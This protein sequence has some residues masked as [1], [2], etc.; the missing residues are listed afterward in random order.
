[1]KQQSRQTFKRARTDEERLDRREHILET[2]ETLL[3]DQGIESFTMTRLA[4]AANLAKGTAYLYFPTKNDLLVELFTRKFANWSTR[5]LEG[6]SPGIA[7]EELAALFLSTATHDPLFM[8]L[9]NRVTDTIESE[10]TTDKVVRIKRTN[11]EILQP[12]VIKFSECVGLEFPTAARL[13][14]ALISLVI[15]ASLID[16]STKLQTTEYDTDVR[17]LIGRTS[18]Q[19]VFME[20]ALLAIT[21]ARQIG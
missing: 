5:F 6:L 18:M 17:K 8:T 12:I 19:R 7:D 10:E 2:A 1:M 11:Q 4:V 9:A 16:T 13:M 21:G 3:L 15:G 14:W 20:S